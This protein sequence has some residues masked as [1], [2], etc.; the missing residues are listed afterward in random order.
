MENVQDH[1]YLIAGEHEVKA[2][3]IEDFEQVDDVHR[4]MYTKHTAFKNHFTK[5]AYNYFKYSGKSRASKEAYNNR[6]DRYFFERCL[7]KE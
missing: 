1:W 3:Q 6:K 4:L 7:E 5:A 2:E